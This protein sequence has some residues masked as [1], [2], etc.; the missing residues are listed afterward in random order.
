MRILSQLLL[1]V[2][3]EFH[4]ALMARKEVSRLPASSEVR[5]DKRCVPPSCWHR[6][7]SAQRA[8]DA[9][10]L[11]VLAVEPVVVQPHLTARAL[12]AREVEEVAHFG[13]SAG[14]ARRHP[15]V[16]VNIGLGNSLLAVET[17]GIVRDDHRTVHVFVVRRERR[18]VAEL[19]VGQRREPRG[20]GLH[21]PAD[22]VLRALLVRGRGLAVDKPSLASKGCNRGNKG[23]A[24]W[25]GAHDTT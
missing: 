10:R 3:K 17:A 14:V 15:H 1:R 13:G 11:A 8:V 12:K 25:C 16:R 19:F 22:R 20:L 4:L 18:P 24:T 6:R 23:I 5:I 9:Y 21:P 2:V 7:R